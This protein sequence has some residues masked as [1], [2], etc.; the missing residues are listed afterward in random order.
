MNNRYYGKWSYQLHYEDHNRNFNRLT[1][2]VATGTKNM[3]RTKAGR[4]T[5][6]GERIITRITEKASGGM[7]GCLMQCQL[8]HLPPHTI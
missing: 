2:S 7:L 4:Y 8:E 1:E 6:D 3:A 5:L